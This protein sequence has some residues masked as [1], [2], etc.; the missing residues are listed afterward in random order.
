MN[1]LSFILLIIFSLDSLSSEL[2]DLKYR[3]YDLS[4]FKVTHKNLSISYGKGE[5]PIS[6]WKQKYEALKSKGLE[7]ENFPFQWQLV[8]LESGS[9]LSESKSLEKLFYGAS[10]TKIIV[11]SAFLQTIEDPF[12]STYFQDLLD[13]IVVSS[14]P[15]WRK[16]QYACGNENM[17]RGR[18]E[19]H[20]FTQN[21]GLERTRAFWGY[22]ST[23]NG[24]HGNEINVLEFSQFM[25]KLYRGEFFGSELIFKIM[26]TGERVMTWQKDFCQK[27]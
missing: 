25:Q 15:S 23:M 21:L 13:M 12:L 19:I 1:I 7:L 4:Q 10:T 16:I 27:V 11:G 26:L 5:A 17:E 6:H 18:L 8:D 3:D 9:V 2:W 14:N 20:Q 24:L 22:S